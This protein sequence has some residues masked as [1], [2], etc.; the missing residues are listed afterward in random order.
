MSGHVHWEDPKPIV[1]DVSK[2]WLV[3]HAT[4]VVAVPFWL[5]LF[6]A[7][8]AFF[9]HFLA[10]CLLAWIVVMSLCFLVRGQA[11][12][13]YKRRCDAQSRLLDAHEQGRTPLAQTTQYGAEIAHVADLARIAF[14]DNAPVVA[15]VQAGVD[16][17]NEPPP[18]D[19]S[20]RGYLQRAQRAAREAKAMG[21]PE[22]AD[23]KAREQLAQRWL[24]AAE[25][26]ERAGGHDVQ[27]R[28][29]RQ[30]A[31]RANPHFS[32]DEPKPRRRQSG[33]R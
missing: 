29:A 32:N 12:A 19:P 20:S 26:Y 4:T 25:S 30:H 27:A 9:C 22:P 24:D 10:W 33:N 5:S 2:P 18:A 7:V 8:F 16:K 13:A 31:A 17:M 23:E 6:V 11:V 28:Q 21:V 1:R 3:A 15:A 14:R